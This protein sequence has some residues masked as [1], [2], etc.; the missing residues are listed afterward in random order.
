M[1][2]LGTHQKIE[3]T[4]LIITNNPK[5]NTMKK[6]K[7]GFM[8]IAAIII[9]SCTNPLDKPIN[10]KDF[11]EVKELI[12]SD[13]AYSP[14]KRKYIIDN[15]S[16]QLG[17]LE[18]GKTMGKAMGKEMDESK[19]STFRQEIGELSMTFDST[20]IAKIDI[21]NNN[22][23][24]KNFVELVDANTISIDKYKGYL[25]MKLKFNNQF[26]K[27]ILYIIL[28]YK[29]I[30]KYDSEFFDE[31]TKLTDEV[32]GDFKRELEVSTTEKYN[33]VAEF[34]YTKVPIQASKALRDKLGVEK[35]NTKVK[36]DF[37]ME[38]LKV[39]TLGIVFKDKTEL[40]HQN[41]DWEYLEN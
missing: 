22:E 26:E 2:K 27:E 21:K 35:A 31:K 37:L 15:I 11:V 5:T 9:T 39:E 32:A 23:K 33:D 17:Y 14:M 3:E 1:A 8:M 38:G 6:F 29:Y 28:N 18:L 13:T 20:R 34:M 40:V 4:Y 19:I 12:S 10:N 30:N 41:A 36:H 16:E 7:F 24:L 25:T